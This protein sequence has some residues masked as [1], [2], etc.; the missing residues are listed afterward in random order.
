MSPQQHCRWPA[1]L[2][3]LRAFWGQT[4]NLGRGSVVLPGPFWQVLALVAGDKW[5]RHQAPDSSSSRALR[6]YEPRSEQ[7][8][9]VGGGEGQLRAATKGRCLDREGGTMLRPVT[10]LLCDTDGLLLGTERLCSVV[11]RETCGRSGRNHTW[12][13]QS[14]VRKLVRHLRKHNIPSAA[15]AS[16][17]SASL[18]MKTSRNKEFFGLFRHLVLGD[19]PGVKSG[20][21]E[22]DIFLACAKRLSPP[23][24]VEQGLVV[25]DAPNGLQAALAA[26]M[27]AVTAPDGPLSHDLTAKATPVLDSLQDFRPE[28]FGLP[29]YG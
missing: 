9:G 20:K 25:E 6:L 10:C 2:G 17:G 24:P 29:S 28:L 5:R 18:E 11:F 19:D 23:P 22:P 16:S 3:G 27:Q 26:G 21:P 1:T 4:A 14:L 7:D 12:D 8:P 13:V 15:A